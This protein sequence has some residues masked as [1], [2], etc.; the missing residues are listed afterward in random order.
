MCERAIKNQSQ[1]KDLRYGQSLSPAQEKGLGK[2]LRRNLNQ[3]MEDEE[4]HRKAVE[5]V[6]NAVSRSSHSGMTKAEQ[7]TDGCPRK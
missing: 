7:I 6:T 5:R 1:L 4:A 3:G 2:V